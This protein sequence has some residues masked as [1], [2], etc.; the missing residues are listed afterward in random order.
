MVTQKK[1]IT[2]S[3]SVKLCKI[4]TYDIRFISS[5]EVYLCNWNF[6]LTGK[7]QESNGCSQFIW[8]VN[9]RSLDQK[10][11]CSNQYSFWRKN[12]AWIILAMIAYLDNEEV[13]DIS[14]FNF[15]WHF[16]LCPKWLASYK[17]MT[18]T[19]LSWSSR[20]MYS[21]PTDPY[22][23]GMGRKEPERTK[24]TKIFK[25]TASSSRC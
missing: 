8:G 24:S 23:C 20:T 18:L 10:T 12:W 14:C 25:F 21:D 15:Y 22:Q 7:N 9:I 2:V 6:Y 17:R 5:I 11:L 19:F 16:Q 1:C 3:D 4:N 13:T